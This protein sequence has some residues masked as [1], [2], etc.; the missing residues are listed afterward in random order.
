MITLKCVCMGLC[1][2]G[3]TCVC[4]LGGDNKRESVREGLNMSSVKHTLGSF[5]RYTN[6]RCGEK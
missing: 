3:Y 1:V 6:Y 2:C 4:A 5:S